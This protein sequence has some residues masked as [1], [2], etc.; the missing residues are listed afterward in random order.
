MAVGVEK[1]LKW[2]TVP[3]VPLEK[4]CSVG[5]VDGRAG[6]IGDDAGVGILD[7]IVP[8]KKLSVVCF[9]FGDTDMVAVVV[10]Q[11]VVLLQFFPTQQNTLIS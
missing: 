11:C 3:L 2:L 6:M 4:L 8:A 5:D 1:L 7:V 9:V 10:A